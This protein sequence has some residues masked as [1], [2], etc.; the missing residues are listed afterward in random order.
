MY[1][2]ASVFS[3]DYFWGTI[4]LF[5]F[6]FLVTPLM[7]FFCPSGSSAQTKRKN[8]FVIRRTGAPA[9]DS[10]GQSSIL[11][12]GIANK[13]LVSW[14]IKRSQGLGG[15]WN[16][17]TLHHP[18]LN[19]LGRI[20]TRILEK[21][22]PWVPSLLTVT[23]DLTTGPQPFCWMSQPRL[24]GDVGRTPGNTHFIG[25][26]LKRLIPSGG[27]CTHPQLYGFWSR[28]WW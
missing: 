19:R 15:V 22:E 8:P 11:T 17:L 4:F 1:L 2:G 20:V 14:G 12:E 9:R 27:S 3:L 24:F 13:N 23:W 26:Q 6:F 10:P 16:F 28:C 7:S 25:G 21:S 5:F 18:S